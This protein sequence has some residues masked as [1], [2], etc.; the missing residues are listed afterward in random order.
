MS[1]KDLQFETDNVEDSNHKIHHDWYWRA[2]TYNIRCILFIFSNLSDEIGQRTFFSVQLFLRV[3]CTRYRFECKISERLK[4]NVTGK[5]RICCD[6]KL[7]LPHGF[8]FHY[9][10][11]CPLILADNDYRIGLSSTINC[12][13]IIIWWTHNHQLFFLLS[14]IVVISSIL[15]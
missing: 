5:C 2:Q 13:C 6:S 1:S 4:E 14:S 11:C 7:V 9:L 10:L 3:K 15:K 12:S 8:F